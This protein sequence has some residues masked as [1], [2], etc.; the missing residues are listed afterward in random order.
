MLAWVNAATFV[1]TTGKAVNSEQPQQPWGQHSC[2]SIQ[3]GIDTASSASESGQ[4]AG[5]GSSRSGSSSSSTSSSCGFF[6]LA[7]R[8]VLVQGG[9]YDE[10][11]T[12]VQRGALAPP[13]LTVW[14][15]A[16][17]SSDSDASS[18]ENDGVAH[19]VVVW[20]CGDNDALTVIGD[21]AAVSLFGL[22]IETRVRLQLNDSFGCIFVHG[23]ASVDVE[24]CDLSTSCGTI[25]DVHD[26]GSVASLVHNTMH[27]SD[28]HAVSVQSSATARL[29]GN[30]IFRTQGVLFRD[31]GTV[32]RMRG[33]KVSVSTMASVHVAHGATLTLE[34]GGDDDGDDGGGDDGAMSNVIEGN[35]RTTPCLLLEGEGTRVAVQ[36]GGLHASG[37]DWGISVSEGAFLSCDPEAAVGNPK[38]K[39]GKGSNET[40]SR[41]GR[42]RGKGKGKGKD[43]RALKPPSDPPTSRLFDNAEGGVLA[44]G[45]CT[46]VQLSRIQLSAFPSAEDDAGFGVQTCMDADLDADDISID[47]FETAINISGSGTR[48]SL[49]RVATQRAR[50]CGIS[51]DGGCRARLEQCRVAACLSTGISVRGAGTDATLVSND[52]SECNGA[53]ILVDNGPTADS[54]PVLHLQGNRTKNNGISGVQFVEDDTAIN[55]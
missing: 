51:L 49:Q 30:C 9:V 21:S 19:S 6:G 2:Y 38:Q 37:G 10:E 26:V 22:T 4:V 55:D 32:G 7:G 40:E 18:S 1:V 8:L 29:L 27:D 14:P 11:E 13:R 46:R 24:R 33:N 43:R 42:E 53:A 15:M 28:Y 54:C 31:D 48:A 12:L 16:W 52:V 35:S 39:Q 50:C 36:P 17:P 23:G 20:R 41:N 47:G 3:E 44:Q 34:Y 5:I 45:Q 25:V